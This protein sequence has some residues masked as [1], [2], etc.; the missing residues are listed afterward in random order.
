MVDRAN[1]GAPTPPITLDPEPG[2]IR[3]RFAASAVPVADAVIG[4]LRDVCPTVD[5]T[6]DTL[7]TTGRDWWPL[8]V[9]WALNGEVPARAAAVARPGNAA[10]VAAVLAVCHHARVPVTAMGGRSGVCGNAVPVFG[11]VQ[12]DLTGLHGIRGVDDQSLLVDVAAGTFGDVQE[13]A[14]RGDHGL[15]L[16]HWPQSMALSTVG[17]WV[18]CRSAGQY[19]TRYGKIED[20]VTGL[21]V[22]LADGRVITTGGAAPRAATGP[23]LTQVFV[24]SEGTLGVIT[25]VRLRA[26]PVPPAESRAAWAF[27]SF[28]DGLDA[29]RRTLRR[30]ASPAVLRLYDAHES[31]SAFGVEGTSVL[32]VLD[33][34][35]PLIVDATMAVAADE[36]TSL[37]GQPLDPDLV[38]RWVARRDDIS[39]LEKAVRAGLTVDTIEVAARW[40]ALQALYQE[41]IEAVGAVEGTLL[42]SAHLSHAYPDG[43]CL[44]FSFAGQPVDAGQNAADRTADNTA[45]TSPDAAA[46]DSYYRR[47]WDV[48][49]DTTVARG[50]AISHHHG[51]GLNRGRHLGRALGP[52]FDVLVALKEALDPNGVLNP[53]KLGLPSPFGRVPW[54]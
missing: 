40:T 15:T 20:M 13:E 8:G 25:E 32:I 2:A 28:A 21:Q 42:A 38:Q 33:E 54:P 14:L 49:M 12:L 22:A 26:H 37:A 50:G 23:D 18:A 5:T 24:G 31:R 44:Y 3:A 51:V 30:G 6:P 52:A 9:T 36:C 53:G 10:E 16:G 34:G 7:T 29:C 4:R 11:G 19:S 41:A 47:V 45:R 46:G 35:D 27:G 48:V 39:V 1:R 43:G 17:G